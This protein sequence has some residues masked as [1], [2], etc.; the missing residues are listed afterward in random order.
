MARRLLQLTGTLLAGFL[1]CFFLLHAVPGDPA[2][3]LDD[4]AIPA[5]QAERTRRALGLDRP[6]PAQLMDTLYGYARG[7]FG[8]STTR[9]R[10]VADVLAEAL[11]PTL[12]LGTAA[13]VLAYGVGLPLSLLLIVTPTR[14]RRALDGGLLAVATVPRFWLGL[15]LIFVLHGLAGWFPASHALPPGGG[16]WLERLRH[17]VLPALALGLPAASIVARYQLA[18]MER[19]LADPHV[20]AARASGSMGFRL[21]ATH[22]LRPRLGASIALLALDLPVLVSGAV[23]IEIVF[24]WPGLGRLS[25]EAIQG[26]DYPLALAAATLSVAAVV[27]G[28]FAA[29]TVTRRLTP[30]DGA[31]DGGAAA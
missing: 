31:E 22:V 12:L 29:E 8:V 3:R 16:D 30:A 18:A 28:R 15:M 27:F 20:R 23:V 24:A 7:E 25:A 2:D 11:P 9:R 13:L 17:L 5:E 19:T 4:P 26:H 6:L 10:P 14:F 1:I 21:Y